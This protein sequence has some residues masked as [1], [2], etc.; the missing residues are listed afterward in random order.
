[1][2]RADVVFGGPT[3][4]DAGGLSGTNKGDYEYGACIGS[5]NFHAEQVGDGT[6]V[7]PGHNAGGA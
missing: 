1:M 3:T 7:T 2:S 4:T 5:S 6:H